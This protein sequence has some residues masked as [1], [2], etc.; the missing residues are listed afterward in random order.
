MDA[1]I[2]LDLRLALFQMEKSITLAEI[3]S[4]TPDLLTPKQALRLL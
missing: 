2:Q 3:R 4:M 1:K